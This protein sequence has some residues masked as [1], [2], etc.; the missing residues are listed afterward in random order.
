MATRDSGSDQDIVHAGEHCAVQRRECRRLD[1]LE[2]VDADRV[3]MA[4]FRQPDLD[5]V[6]HDQEVLETA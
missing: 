4:F 5:E 6:G 2:V 3:G 1:L